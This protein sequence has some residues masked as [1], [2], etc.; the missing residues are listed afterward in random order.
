[1]D[2]E[3]H[4][5]IP[6]VQYSERFALKWGP[7]FDLSEDNA[8][9]ILT[10]FEEIHLAEV[11]SWSMA[12][13][14][15]GVRY[16]NV[17]VGDTGGVIP[18]VGGMA[19]Y[20]T[21]DSSGHPMIVLA[22]DTVTDLPYARSV[23]AHE[24]FHAVQWASESFWTWETGSWFWEATATWAAGEVVPDNDSYWNALPHYALKPQIGLYHDTMTEHGGAP[25]DLHQYGAFIF[26]R[27]ISEV[28]ES[29]ET[30]LSAWRDGETDDDPVAWM[31]VHMT[32]EVFGAA[33]VDHAAHNLTWD[34]IHGERWSSWVDEV[35]SW[36]P[37]QDDRIAPLIAHA[38]ADW[39]TVG[40][41]DMPGAGG[42][43]L[44]PIPDDVI[45]EG[46]LVVAVRPDIEAGLATATQFRARV[47]S[48][49]DGVPTRHA[50]DHTVPHTT[51]SVEP[52]AELWLVVAK[53][54]LLADFPTGYKVAFFPQPDFPEEA[55]PE[56]TGD[57]PVD[58]GEPLTPDTGE[59]PQTTDT[60]TTESP[61]PVEDTGTSPGVASNETTPGSKPKSGCSCTT[62]G[63]TRTGLFWLLLP[64]LF[65]RRGDSTPQ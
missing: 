44:I 9:A 59:E 11:E 63:T 8:N 1:M 45:E 23:I 3:V 38:D 41:E 16:F 43:N 22:N 26:P 7:D 29:P 20:Y 42:Y 5:A 18:S 65:I 50:V 56:D 19:G 31:R 49:V 6:N 57:T 2:H 52:T 47:V 48:I 15:D 40:D 35:A 30:I 17:Y 64:L 60:G 12:S 51:L 24:F 32:D 14:T 13:P 4:G 10:H 27:Y 39:Y 25:P 55:P 33:L 28:L 53:L 54:S 61:P 58:T 21:T 34:Y 37:D 46:E 62:G 36:Y